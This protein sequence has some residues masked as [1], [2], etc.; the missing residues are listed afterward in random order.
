MSINVKLEVFEGPLDLLLHLIEKSKLNIYDVS[1]SAVTDQFLEHIREMA[2]FNMDIASEFLVMASTLLKI[3]S[4]LLLPKE[5]K[6]ESEDKSEEELRKK[7][8]EYKKFKLLSE[9]LRTKYNNGSIY[10]Y[11]ESSLPDNISVYGEKAN[12]IKIAREKGLNNFTLYDRYIDIIKR[13][14]YKKD[15]VRSQFS[16]RIISEPVNVSERLE[17]IRK[18]MAVNNRLN[19]KELL[20]EKNTKTAEIVTFLILLEMMKN[21]AVDVEQNEQFGDIDITVN[22]I[23]ED[24]GAV[25]ELE[26][27]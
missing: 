19:F 2:V 6:A 20:P 11:R 1:I 23:P 5:E 9:E 18:L 4:K 8:I 25:K 21:G 3:K 22:S 13:N 16:G 15:R 10:F 24:F 26:D 14:L 27:D 17:E 7:L 12:V